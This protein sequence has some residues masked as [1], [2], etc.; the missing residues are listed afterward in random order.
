MIYLLTL[1]AFLLCIF[2]VFNRRVNTVKYIIIIALVGIIAYF[3]VPHLTD[4]L[5]RYFME[6]ERLGNHNYLWAMEK[7]TWKSN[8]ISN[9]LL[10]ILGKMG[11]P[12]FLPVLTS[13]CMIIVFYFLMRKHFTDKYTYSGLSL[14]FTEFVFGAF[15]D[16]YLIMN[17][18]RNTIAMLF[19]IIILQLDY[20]KKIKALPLKILLYA[21]LPFIHYSML[22]L[23]LIV[24]FSKIKI[25]SNL[26]YLLM[27]AS[28]LSINVFIKLFENSNID[29][30]KEVSEKSEIYKGQYTMGS[31]FALTAI[32]LLV[33]VLI[34]I[35]LA[36]RL[37]KMVKKSGSINNAP[38]EYEYAELI[39][40]LAIAMVSIFFVSQALLFRLFP[41][42]VLLASPYI[43]DYVREKTNDLN[44]KIL[45]I[46]GLL[47]CSSVR[48]VFQYIN[49]FSIWQLSI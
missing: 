43:Y 37:K 9:T 47:V 15:L 25:S 45:I 13:T 17:I 34:I 26:K 3:T 28:P 7:G 27:A 49:Y 19:F 12:E 33:A 16:V 2:S 10:F 29:M 31:S 14:L 41:L 24:F 44:S 18:V 42:L 21:I 6:M 46:A 30:L 4:D 36:M 23:V 22:P 8:W 39:L 11:I 38:Q 40:C 1:L 48:W 5:S 20:R 35:I 32:T